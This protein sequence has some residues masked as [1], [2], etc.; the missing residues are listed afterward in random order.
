MDKDKD[1][2]GKPSL[3]QDSSS[4]SPSGS[5]SGSSLSSGEP[6]GSP[7]DNILDLRN[8]VKTYP[9]VTALGGVSFTVR[10]GEV[11]SLVGENGAGKSTLIKTV[12]GAIE[13]DSGEIWV[14]SKLFYSLSPKS[15]EENGVS[16]IY[17]EFNLVPSLSAAEN[18]FLGKPIKKWIMVDK[19]AMEKESEELFKLLGVRI[20]P[21]VEVG[22]LSVG[23]QQI[24]E[25]AKAVSR[26]ARLLIMDEP[27]APLTSQETERMLGLVNTLKERG[28]SIVY[29]SHRLDEVM[30]ISDRITVLRDGHKITT[31]NKKDASV[32]KLVTLMVGREMK[33]TF[34]PR[35][36]KIKEEILIEA[37]NLSGNGVRNISFKAKKGEIVGFAGLVGSG[38]TETAELL[39]G[40]KTIDEGTLKIKGRDVKP[41]NV[42]EAI[43][44]GISLVPE[45][46]KREGLLLSKS[47]LENISLAVLKRISKA[48]V[49]N[50]KKEKELS[51]DYVDKL[52]IKTPS[53]DETAGNLSGG[54]QQK[55]VLAKW[56]A[57]EPDLIIFDE[58]TRG[59]D[60]GA[61]YEIYKLI[62]ALTESG[63][64]VLLISSEMEEL[65]GLS[66]R[67]VVLSE[68][69][70][71]GELSRENFSQERIMA[72]A[73]HADPDRKAG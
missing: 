18:I 54:N 31:L 33:E 6:M 29:I 43:S 61:K 57:S 21:S 70:Q 17:Q 56:L 26:N 62:G 50:R 67:I 10:R 12:S 19:K 7:E 13:P 28:V 42:E 66:D 27:S 40:V 59:I 2:N 1:R 9:G 49:I 41:K 73:S 39:F 45:D 71:T 60:V 68:G 4:P 52:K 64:T 44:L 23:F 30:K 63:R 34:P 22:N 51:V 48:L 3:L 16:V 53:V 47:V 15:S 69:K 37:E 11:H 36:R 46:R 8:I 35:E 55:V 38:R 14:D 5:P 65:I 32:P 58:P 25:I 20:D 72:L 24:V